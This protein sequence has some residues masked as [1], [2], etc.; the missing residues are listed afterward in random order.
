[1]K[2]Q[3]YLDKIFY[4]LSFL[5][6]NIELKNSLNLTDINIVS[7]NFYRDFLNLLYSLNL[8]NIN[9]LVPNAAAIDLGDETKKIA[10]QVTS[11]GKKSKIENTVNLFIENKLFEKYEKLI[12]LV[13]A[14]KTRIKTMIVIKEVFV[15]DSTKDVWDVAKLLRDI[16]D[17]KLGELENIWSFI[18]KEVDL[19]SHGNVINSSNIILLSEPGK[20]KLENYGKMEV[21]LCGSKFDLGPEI[22]NEPRTI[23]INMHYYFRTE[24]LEAR[25]RSRIGMNGKE[26]KSFEVYLLDSAHNEYIARFKLLITIT[27]GAIT[28]HTQQLG[29]S[30]EK[31]SK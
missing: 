25:A 21:F 15:F 5:I 6:T 29:V 7:E 12:I 28:I 1:M 8:R 23:P 10:F 11:T 18:Q 26:L 30:N 24:Q 20:L 4:H 13:I 14:K 9:I 27:N 17:K 16:N 3:Y 2:R 22:L 19:T 31:W